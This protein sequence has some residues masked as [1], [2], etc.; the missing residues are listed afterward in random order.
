MFQDSMRDLV[1]SMLNL[2]KITTPAPSNLA[3]SRLW[4]PLISSVRDFVMHVLL[5][6]RAHMAVLNL[7]EAEIPVSHRPGEPAQPARQY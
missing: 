6:A 7:A 4:L 1:S 3:L 2:A 5:F